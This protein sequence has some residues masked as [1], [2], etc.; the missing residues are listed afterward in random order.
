MK[1]C[2]KCNFSFPDFHHVCDF[3]GTELVLDP[4]PR[5]LMRVPQPS[6]PRRSLKSSALLTSL[7]I[8]ALFLSAVLIGYF[9]SPDKSIP[10]VKDQRAPNSLGSATPV[11]RASEQSAA[12]AKTP[13]ASKRRSVTGAQASRLRLNKLRGSS[14]AS[15][16]K[17][18]TPQSLTRVHQ[19]SSDRDRSGKS[20]IAGRRDSQQVSDKKEPKLTA[21]LKTT[22]NVLKKPFKF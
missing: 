21:I 16:P 1:H 19:R 4:E 9:Q 13:N 10:A 3:D 2:P 7:A 8:L 20:E 14:S 17:A 15:Q 5:S 18:S 12:R 22:W 11:A 6:R